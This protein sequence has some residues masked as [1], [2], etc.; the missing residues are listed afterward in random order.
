MRLFYLAMAIGVSSLGLCLTPQESEAQFRRYYRPYYRPLVTSYYYA[1]YPAVYYPR[2]VYY[3]PAPV[4][5]Q[6]VAYY[7]P[8]TPSYQP[9]QSITDV[10]V[11]V[12]DSYFQP[13]TVNVLPGTTVRWMNYSHRMHTVTAQD[14][15]WDSG[16]LPPGTSY[17]VTFLYTGTYYYYCRHHKEMKGTVIVSNTGGLDTG[18]GYRFPGY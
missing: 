16:D 8:Y 15:S 9:P 3:S 1:P 5:R 14:G 6:P 12:Y 2:P 17:A 10:T 7:T 18:G 13:P 11:G 4:Y